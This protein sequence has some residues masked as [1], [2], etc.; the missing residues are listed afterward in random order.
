VGTAVVASG[1]PRALTVSGSV[2]LGA[3]DVGT[4]D[5]FQTWSLASPKAPVR[6]DTLNL[7]N[8]GRRSIGVAG[9]T[10][11]VTDGTLI[12]AI[13]IADPANITLTGT[14]DLNADTAL[15]T[16]LGNPVN[17]VTAQ[18]LAVSGNYAY[19][20]TS[21][22]GFVVLNI[23]NPAAITRVGFATT[24][25]LGPQGLVVIGTKA[26]MSGDEN[27]VCFGG[28]CVPPS[29]KGVLVFDI[30]TPATP[31]KLGQ[32]SV[33]GSPRGLAVSGTT[34]YVPLSGTQFIVVDV[35]TPAAPAS[36]AAT[37]T[38]GYAYGAAVSGS[39]L[40]VASG[41]T[42]GHLQVYSIAA[43]AAPV[44]LTDE[45]VVTTGGAWAVATSATYAYVASTGMITVID[46]AC[47]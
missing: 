43:P 39:K 5:A 27:Q 4:T 19:V 30:S 10:A 40:Y 13:N 11:F 15:K 37:D 26:Y 36:G 3:D 18:A 9:T 31:T 22:R 24:G 25:S 28:P 8:T 7:T 38:N 2:L 1:S 46:L 45:R 34:A 16:A 41:A 29:F 6:V 23:S 32:G 42:E 44:R 17:G 47:P 14:F 20:A 12:D 33:A 21:D 35:S